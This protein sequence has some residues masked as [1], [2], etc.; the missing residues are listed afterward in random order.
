M[1][2]AHIWILPAMIVT[3]WTL[4][5]WRTWR[6][7]WTFLSAATAGSALCIAFGVRT[8]GR[9]LSW[10]DLRCSHAI[11]CIDQHPV[12]W[13]MTGLISFVCC[14]VLLLVTAVAA[15]VIRL[16]NRAGAN[17]RA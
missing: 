6:I 4:S 10:E 16:E 11:E 3:G 14:G 9:Q 1:E 12:Y 15:V 8:Y 7:R 5:W 17:S 2:K 13:M